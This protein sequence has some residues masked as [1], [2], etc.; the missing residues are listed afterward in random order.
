MKNIPLALDPGG[1][2]SPGWPQSADGLDGYHEHLAVLE[3]RLERDGYLALLR[4]DVS[5]IG[6][7]E[8]AYG[9]GKYV[10]LMN[11]VRQ[12]V[13]EFKGDQLR[14]NDIVALNEKGGDVFLVFLAPRRVGEIL[15]PERVESIGERVDQALSH[16]IRQ[17][18]FAVLRKKPEVH[19]GT[20]LVLRNPLVRTERLVARAIDE[21]RAQADLNGQRRRLREQQMLQA[22]I[23]EE[24]ITIVFQPVWDLTRRRPHGFEALCRGPRDSEL[25]TPA[26]L[27]DVARKSDLLFELDQLC[28]Q[29]ALSA[30]GRRAKLAREYKLFINTLPL[31]IRDPRFQGKDLIDLFDGI[32]LAPDQLVLEVTESDAIDNYPLFVGAMKDLMDLR[33]RVAI[34]DMGAGYSGL[35]KIVHLRPGYVKLDMGLTRD[36]HTSFVK[37]QLVQTFKALADKIGAKLVAEGIEQESELQVVRDLGV[38]SCRE[39]SLAEPSQAFQTTP[40]F[41]L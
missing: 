7:V 39:T 30:A 13:S 21:A 11:M 38:T 4:I 1:E 12:A 6:E 36:V 25:R 40:S 9:A 37:Q 14:E 23:L 29:K 27:F 8:R 34:D 31:S 33:C 35:D 5:E 32:D 3:S 28:R 17:T 20:A 22:I 24:D 15:R 2:S 26:S 19:V 41:R 16:R 10:D 18:A